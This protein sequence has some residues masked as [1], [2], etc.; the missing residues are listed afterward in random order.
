MKYVS[1]YSNI[2]F[3]RIIMKRDNFP[4]DEKHLFKY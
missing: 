3:I 4:G 2:Q 1:Q